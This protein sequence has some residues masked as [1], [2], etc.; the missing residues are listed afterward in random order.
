MAENGNTEGTIF[1]IKRFAVY[2]GPGI[3]TTVFLKGCLLHC[4]WCHNPESISRQP[5]LVFTPPKCIGCGQ[6][7]KVCPQGA[8]QLV[9]GEHVIE[10]DLCQVCGLCAEGC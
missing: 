9:D 5:Q 6:C 1:D 3:R 4:L 10:W 7:I 8:H 2:D